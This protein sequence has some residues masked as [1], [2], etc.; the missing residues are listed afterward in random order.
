MKILGE[1][2]REKAVIHRKNM[3]GE[4]GG[5]QWGIPLP[6]QLPLVSHLYS[7]II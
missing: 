3:N 1:D 5:Q 2:G 6:L 4:T 7:C